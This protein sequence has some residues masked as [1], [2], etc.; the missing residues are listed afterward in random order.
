LIVSGLHEEHR[1]LS[2]AGLQPGAIE[3]ANY[4]D[5]FRLRDLDNNLVTPPKGRSIGSPVFIGRMFW[6]H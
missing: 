3:S 6:L 1:R 2:D 4:L 5:L